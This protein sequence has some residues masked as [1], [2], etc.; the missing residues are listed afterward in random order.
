MIHVIFGVVLCGLIFAAWRSEHDVEMWGLC[1]GILFCLWGLIVL[2][3]Y[4]GRCR[5]EFLKECQQDHKKYECVAMWRAG[6]N[7]AYVPIVIST[8]GGK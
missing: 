3:I 4:D 7:G 2:A 6:K 1:I 5:A 8:R